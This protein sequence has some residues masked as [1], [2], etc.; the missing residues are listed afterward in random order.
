[1]ATLAGARRGFFIPYRYAH[2]LSAPGTRPTYRA[3]DDLLTAREDQFGALLEGVD[4]YASA[5]TAI[6]EE[7]PPAPRWRQDWFPRLDAAIAYVLVR[8]RRPARIIEIGS[9]HSTRFLARDVIDGGLST[10]ITDIDP[11]TRDAMRDLAEAV[12]S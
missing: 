12:V 4:G 11:E 3:L 9:G 10:E 7:P 1:M 8:E 5:L 2:R 6:G